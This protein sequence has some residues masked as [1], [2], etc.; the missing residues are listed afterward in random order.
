VLHEIIATCQQRQFWPCQTSPSKC[1]VNAPIGP[2][3]ETKCQVRERSSCIFDAVCFRITSRR[4]DVP[5]GL[6]QRNARRETANSRTNDERRA[7]PYAD[8]NVGALVGNVSSETMSI[9]IATAMGTTQ[10]ASRVSV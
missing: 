2:V 3:D 7:H 5:S 10:S 9:T 6:P 4:G 8:Q 1:G